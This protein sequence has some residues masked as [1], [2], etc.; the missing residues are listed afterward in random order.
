MQNKSHVWPSHSMLP[1][2]KC[3]VNTFLSKISKH[4]VPLSDIWFDL[5]DTHNLVI[6]K[7]NNLNNALPLYFPLD[8]TSVV[9]YTVCYIVFIYPG[10][11]VVR[12]L[13]SSHTLPLP[14]S[15][16]SFT[17]RFYKLWMFPS[18]YFWYCSYFKSLTHKLQKLFSF[19]GPEYGRVSC[20]IFMQV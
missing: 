13:F 10:S 8:L 19:L 20:C 11:V 12:P 18:C 1:C 6:I 3:W 14:S 9:Y 17:N 15:V 5:L 4:R 16:H 7:T 2:M